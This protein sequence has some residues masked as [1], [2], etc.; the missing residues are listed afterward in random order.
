LLKNHVSD[1]TGWHAYVLMTQALC[2]STGLQPDGLHAGAESFEHLD[3]IRT[4]AYDLHPRYDTLVAEKR[5]FVS[6]EEAIASVTEDIMASPVTVWTHM[7]DPGMRGAWANG[8]ITPTDRPAGR[9]G[10]GAGNHCAHGKSV[11]LESIVDWKPFN[12]W[13]ANMD[14]G[15]MRVRYTFHLTPIEG[16]TRVTSSVVALSGPVPGPVL[17]FMLRRN[18]E[19]GMPENL[20]RLSDMCETHERAHALT[21]AGSGA[22][23]AVSAT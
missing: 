13:T 3:E 14:V 8:V 20:G 2:E 7:H 12:Y 16:G 9:T 23:E 1:E 11:Q 10:T 4:H 15:K 21:P 22:D 6:P 5:V 18:W 19:K 17:R